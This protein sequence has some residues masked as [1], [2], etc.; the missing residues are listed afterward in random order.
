MTVPSVT[1]RIASP[2][3]PRELGHIRKQ[4]VC[5]GQVMGPALSRRQK[6]SRTP[7]PKYRFLHRLSTAYHGRVS[8]GQM[9]MATS[10]KT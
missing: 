4:P 7:S 8:Y 2:E 3:L 9:P 10:A 1:T 6:G 5:V